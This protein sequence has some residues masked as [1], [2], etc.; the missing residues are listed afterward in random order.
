[1]GRVFSPVV[2]GILRPSLLILCVYETLLC[3][4]AEVS[5]DIAF[6]GVHGGAV[7]NVD[8]SDT[9][10]R[11]LVFHIAKCLRLCLLFLG[12]SILRLLRAI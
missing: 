2:E 3:L 11:A 8:G 6:G 7:V 9:R 12:V 1:M 5:A 10:F 4:I